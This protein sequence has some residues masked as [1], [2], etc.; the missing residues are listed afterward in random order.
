MKHLSY[1]VLT[2]RQ[3][4]VLGAIVRLY[5]S[6]AHPVSSRHLSKLMNRRLSPA[7]LRNTMADLE[8]MGFLAQPHTSA[9]RVPTE[10]AY[11]LYVDRMIGRSEVN[12]LPSQQKTFRENVDQEAS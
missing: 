7:T 2:E 3:L 10:L 12:L 8:D 6:S 11:R 1:Q 4:E 5:V 9:G